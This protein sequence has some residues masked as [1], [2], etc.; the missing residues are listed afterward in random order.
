MI[1]ILK[2]NSNNLRREVCYIFGNSALHASAN[3]VSNIL[4]QY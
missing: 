4:R 2:G 1:K 3:V